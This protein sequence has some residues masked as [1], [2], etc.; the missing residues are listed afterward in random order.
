MSNS[1]RLKRVSPAASSGRFQAS[2]IASATANSVPTSSIAP[3]TCRKSGKFTSS[4]RMA[5]STLTLPASRS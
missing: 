1:R 2:T 5:A 3:K 4:G